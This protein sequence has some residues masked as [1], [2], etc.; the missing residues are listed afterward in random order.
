M[1]GRGQEAKRRRATSTF[2]AELFALAIDFGGSPMLRI[3][4]VLLAPSLA[5]WNCQAEA[6]GSKSSSG[7]AKTQHVQGYVRKDGT[8]VEGYWRAPAGH[9]GSGSSTGRSTYVSGTTWSTTS[10]A[11]SVDPEADGQEI[12]GFQDD[13][14]GPRASA[15]RRERRLLKPRSSAD[16]RP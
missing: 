14:A 9:G 6:K 13:T 8:A 5:V 11:S 1:R 7:A 10:G 12:G 4:L 16:I 15:S 3:L 2:Q